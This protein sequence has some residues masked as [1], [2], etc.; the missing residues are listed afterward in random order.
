MPHAMDLRQG[1]TGDAGGVVQGV[2]GSISYSHLESLCAAKR[3]WGE[4]TYEEKGERFRI[5][6]LRLWPWCKYDTS[7]HRIENDL[8]KSSRKP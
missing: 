6:R 1:W 7:L 8:V 3:M 5:V 2:G 4:E